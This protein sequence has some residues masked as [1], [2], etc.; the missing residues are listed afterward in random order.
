MTARGILNS[1]PGNIRHGDDWRGLASKEWLAAHGLKYDPAFC[2]FIAPVYGIR[3]MIKILMAYR[4]RNIDTV[5]EI[6]STWAPPDENDTEA[7][8]R[9][10]SLSVGIDPD[11]P[12]TMTAPWINRLVKAIIFHENGSQPYSDNTIDDALTLAGA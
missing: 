9:F 1:N 11:R 7:Y 8:I 6:I 10:V 12:M 5:R 3:A 4:K 2:Q